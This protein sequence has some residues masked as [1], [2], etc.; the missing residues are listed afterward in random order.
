[1]GRGQQFGCPEHPGARTPTL[2]A[3]MSHLHIHCRASPRACATFSPSATR[4]QQSP[5]DLILSCPGGAGE[6]TVHP[7]APQGARVGA[8]QDRSGGW[9]PQVWAPRGQSWS[10]LICTISA[11]PHGSSF[12]TA[13]NPSCCVLGSVWAVD[14]VQ[15]AALGG[16]GC[17]REARRERAWGSMLPCPGVRDGF[18]GA[19]TQSGRGRQ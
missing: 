10:T 9:K 12:S 15:S 18:P 2:V 5:A 6:L 3:L 16:P 17:G 4:W 13:A 7:G 14:L 19:L 8:L 1:M 11:S